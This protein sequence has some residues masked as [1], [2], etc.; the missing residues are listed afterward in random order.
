MESLC[1]HFSFPLDQ[2]KIQYL[3]LDLFFSLI[4]TGISRPSRVNVVALFNI[5]V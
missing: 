4:N 3:M 2:P 1:R 5:V